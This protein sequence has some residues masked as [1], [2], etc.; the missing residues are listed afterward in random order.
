MPPRRRP[1]YRLWAQLPDEL[2]R[3]IMRLVHSITQPQLAF[4]F[5]DYMD[6]DDNGTWWS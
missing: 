1:N 5:Y 2:F 6:D 3:I 4:H